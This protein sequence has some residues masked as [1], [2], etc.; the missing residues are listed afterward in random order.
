MKDA[1]AI[2]INWEGTDGRFVGGVP[3]SRNRSIK[4]GTMRAQNGD[5]STETLPTGRYV[6]PNGSNEAQKRVFW[7]ALRRVQR[8]APDQV[9]LELR[10]DDAAFAFSVM[11]DSSGKAKRALANLLSGAVGQYE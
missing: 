8:C 3:M 1:G 5:C 10:P 2:N 7:M 11:Q 9:V 4:G 6:L